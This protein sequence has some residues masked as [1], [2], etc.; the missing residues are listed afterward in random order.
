MFFSSR[1]SYLLLNC[2]APH[3]AIFWLA[4]HIQAKPD[5]FVLSMWLWLDLYPWQ[6][7]FSFGSG[8]RWRFDLAIRIKSGSKSHQGKRTGAA[9]LFSVVSSMPTT[10]VSAS[11]DFAVVVLSQMLM[12]DQLLCAARLKT[13][14]TVGRLSVE[15]S[16]FYE[17]CPWMVSPVTSVDCREWRVYVS[18]LFSVFCGLRVARVTSI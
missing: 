1:F 4:L 3:L 9:Q 11:T 5:A 2:A 6:L 8:V 10:C 15:I 18:A 14:Q 7:L 17:A 16:S 13:H 12:P